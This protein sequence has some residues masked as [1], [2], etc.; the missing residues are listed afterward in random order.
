MATISQGILPINL[1]KLPRRQ[2][3]LRIQLKDLHDK[4]ID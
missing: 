4:Y 2:V 3:R 1:K